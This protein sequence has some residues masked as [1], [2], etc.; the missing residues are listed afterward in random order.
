MN[1]NKPDVLR[2]IATAAPLL[3]A[4]QRTGSFSAAGA[5]MAQTQST[6]SH[7]IRALEN[8]LGFQLFVR[9]TRQVQVTRSGDIICNAARVS[10][11]ALTEALERIEKLGSSK[12]TILTLSSSLAM[13]WLV[14][15]MSRARD[16]GLKLSLQIDDALSDIGAEGQPQIAIRFGIGPYPGLHAELLTKCEVF[17]VKAKAGR[18]LTATTQ[19]KPARLL[20]DLRAEAD[21]TAMS[22]EAYIEAAKLKGLPHEYGP[23]FERSDLMI[24]AAVAGLGHALGR[25]LLIEADIADALLSVDGPPAPVAGRYWLVTTPEHARTESYARVADW[26]RAE[27]EHSKRI[28]SSRLAA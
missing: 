17:P 12:E 11:D 15:A 9:T 25:T 6:V 28:L 3:A 13:K 20:R 22:W 19:D 4:I 23:D 18:R 5:E 14:P 24:Q 21:G 8:A 10:V 2:R 1:V 27:A 26:L 7:K 16:R